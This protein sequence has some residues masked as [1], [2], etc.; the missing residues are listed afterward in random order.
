M[1]LKSI[2]YEDCA[3]I[4]TCTCHFK[5]K[6]EPLVGDLCVNDASNGSEIKQEENLDHIK[7]EKE[8]VYISSD[9]PPSD[10]PPSASPPSESP[11]SDSPPSDSP[12][13]DSPQNQDPLV[14]FPIISEHSHNSVDVQMEVEVSTSKQITNIV[15]CDDDLLLLKLT[16]EQFRAPL[17]SPFIEKISDS[18]NL[19]SPQ[20]FQKHDVVCSNAIYIISDGKDRKIRRPNRRGHRPKI[21]PNSLNGADRANSPPLD[22]PSVFKHS[23][24]NEEVCTGAQDPTAVTRTASWIPTSSSYNTPSGVTDALNNRTYSYIPISKETMDLYR[25]S[26]GCSRSESGEQFC[27]NGSQPLDEGCSF[28]N[29]D[30][31]ICKK[32]DIILQQK[33]KIAPNLNSNEVR[34]ETSSM[35]TGTTA[36]KLNYEKEYRYKKPLGLKRETFAC[37]ICS[38]NFTNLGLRKHYKFDHGVQ[39]PFPCFKCSLRCVSQTEL[40]QHTTLRHSSNARKTLPSS[41]DFFQVQSSSKNNVQSMSKQVKT[42]GALRNVKTRAVKC[43]ECG[44]RHTSIVDLDMHMEE[45]HPLIP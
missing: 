43:I 12:P 21:P 32:V 6:K 38:R 11:P 10:S 8:I 41:K 20:A 24:Q 3:H 7:E 22:D 1:E 18:H 19:R 33:R 9:S 40:D 23:S 16:P 39:F 31:E 5:N 36:L 29:S 26:V 2:K 13:S 35:T 30:D 44:A 15:D 28:K 45:Q 14:L 27:S 37:T 4:S 17:I 25:K 34:D 42:R